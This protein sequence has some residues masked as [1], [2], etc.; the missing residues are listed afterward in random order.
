[1][2]QK[3]LI[4]GIALAANLL[5]WPCLM[6]ALSVAHERA[7]NPIIYVALTVTVMLT[8]QALAE[9]VK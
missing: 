1:M 5:F 9:R 2:M 3:R 4:L 8:S 6:L 7:A